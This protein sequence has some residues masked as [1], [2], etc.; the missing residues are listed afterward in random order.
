MK[1]YFQ[2]KTFM[3]FAILMAFFTMSFGACNGLKQLGDDLSPYEDVAISFTEAKLKQIFK[4]N[5]LSLK[6]DSIFLDTTI[7]YEDLTNIFSGKILQKFTRK[8]YAEVQTLNIRT[9]ANWLYLANSNSV[10]ITFIRQKVPQ[11]QN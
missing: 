3:F 7:P 8:G 2:G 4:L 6:R 10:Q 5:D 11:S 9:K 1:N